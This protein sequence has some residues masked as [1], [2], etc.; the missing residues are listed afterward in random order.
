M[1]RK[2]FALVVILLIVVAVL[3]IGGIA[4]YEMRKSAVPSTVVSTIIPSTAS[5]SINNMASSS[6]VIPWDSFLTPVSGVQ[7]SATTTG[8]YSVYN[9]GNGIVVK[10]H[11]AQYGGFDTGQIYLNGNEVVSDMSGFISIFQDINLYEYQIGDDRY[12]AIS[13]SGVSGDGGVAGAAEEAYVYN[14]AKGTFVVI[15]S[16]G[17]GLLGHWQGSGNQN[18]P[19]F[20]WY[21]RNNIPYVVTN[22][23]LVSINGTSISTGILLTRGAGFVEKGGRWYLNNSGKQYMCSPSAQVGQFKAIEEERVFGSS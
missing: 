9:D 16:D 14:P 12:I 4:Y 1:N 8:D 22:N 17:G 6:Q 2:G 7:L 5:T 11:Q 13:G 15:G 21:E 19:S 3:I 18:P 20:D 10:L 23:L